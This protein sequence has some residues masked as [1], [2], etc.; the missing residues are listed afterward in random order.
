MMN[1][2]MMRGGDSGGMMFFSWI[3]YILVVIVL[4]LSIGALWKYINKK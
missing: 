1:Y 3:I 2:D 4:V